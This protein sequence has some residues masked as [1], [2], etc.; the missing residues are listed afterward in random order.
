MTRS[1]SIDNI[2]NV[3]NDQVDD[4]LYLTTLTA[5]AVFHNGREDGCTPIHVA[6]QGGCFRA[7]CRLIHTYRLQIILEFNSMLDVNFSLAML[8]ATRP[9]DN[10][11]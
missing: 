8:L 11:R 10:I 7:G 3:M 6:V 2:E 5:K 9:Y 1:S 4:K